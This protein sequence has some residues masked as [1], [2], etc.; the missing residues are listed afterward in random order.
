MEV[1]KTLLRA[2]P[3]FVS[4]FDSSVLMEEFLATFDVEVM[5]KGGETKL[6]F[7]YWGWDGEKDVV[8][9]GAHK[10]HSTN[11]FAVTQGRTTTITVTIRT[12]VKRGGLTYISVFSTARTDNF[13]SGIIRSKGG[14]IGEGQGYCSVLLCSLD[15]GTRHFTRLHGSGAERLCVAEHHGLSSSAL[16]HQSAN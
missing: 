14:E 6:S 3:E 10:D 7:I 8:F 1:T 15:G 12:I 2:Q 16:P 4:W 5:D 9:N 13:G 11:C